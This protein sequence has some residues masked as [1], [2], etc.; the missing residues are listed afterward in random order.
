MAIQFLDNAE[1]SGTVSVDNQGNS[2]EWNKGYGLSLSKLSVTGT[3]IKTLTATTQDGSEIKTSWTDL[4]GVV[5]VVANNGLT[6][7]GE[8]E[9]TIGIQYEGEKNIINS[10]VQKNTGIDAKDLILYKDNED[11]IVYSAR[12]V[13]LITASGVITGV[14]AGTGMTGGGSTGNVQLNV[15]GGSGITA[16]ANDI[17]VDSTVVR[18]SGTQTIGGAKTFSSIPV[19]GTIATANDSTSAASTDLG[20]KSRIHN[21]YTR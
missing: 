20:K 7:S 3:T 4:S 2:E 11:E 12:V 9:V 17:A 15:I 19:V 14:D 18:T 10:A 5:S 8:G 1:F 21:F 13:D 16:N 6:S